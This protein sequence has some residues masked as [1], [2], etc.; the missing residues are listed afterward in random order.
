MR[1]GRMLTGGSV[2]AAVIT[3]IDLT[4]DVQ[5]C[6]SVSIINRSKSQDRYTN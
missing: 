3:Q 5:T 2:H 6:A 4:V 1:T